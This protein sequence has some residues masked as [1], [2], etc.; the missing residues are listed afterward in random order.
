MKAANRRPKIFECATRPSVQARSTALTPK[1]APTSGTRCK[2]G[3]KRT[4]NATETG[5]M[6]ADSQG[7]LT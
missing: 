5:N 4:W 6:T 7:Q 1:N 3:P 2:D